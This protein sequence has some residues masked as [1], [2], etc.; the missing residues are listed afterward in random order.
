MA[1]PGSRICLGVIVGAKGIGGEVRI[2]SF[3][4]DPFD[5]GSYGPVESEDKANTWTVKVVGESKGTVT[6]KLKGI[7]DRNQAEALKGQKLYVDRSQLPE[8]DDG[9]YYHADLIGLRAVLTTGEEIGSVL[10]LYNFGAGDIIEVG[11]GE[12]DST[13]VPF[14]DD[15]VVEVNIEGGFI[16]I[17]PLPG[18]F[19]D[20]EGDEDEGALEAANEEGE[21]NT[22]L[23]DTLTSGTAVKRRE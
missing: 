19:D 10:A 15:A 23:D 14:S 7:T 9:T 16:R 11:H 17:E 1:D 20:G 18:I 21:D 4:E 3:T 5:V 6:A 12:R 13:L 8:A 22:G 2:K